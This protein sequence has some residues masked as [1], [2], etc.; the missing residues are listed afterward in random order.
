MFEL[1]QRFYDP[2]QGSIE[3]GDQTFSKDIRDL[4]LQALRQN[5]GVVS[6]QPSLFT[7]NV[8][9]NI[10]YGDPDATDEQVVE[11]AKSAYAHEFIQHLPDGYNSHLGEQGVK[12]S[13][14]Q[15]QRIAI[16]RAI[17][18]NP[19]ILFLDEATSALD[20]ESEWHVQQALQRL[21]VNRTT[22]VIAHR[23]STIEYADS[24]AVLDQG[25]VIGI[26]T[27]ESLLQNNELYR[28]LARSEFSD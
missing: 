16:A 13:G 18:K 9:D 2:Q 10:R 21:M 24:I 7:Q 22:L 25:E 11:A 26:G 17:L 12:L 23:L 20:N 6:Q 5:I 4:D 15:R 27:H 8:L 1:L 3:L 19:K 28:K 14:G